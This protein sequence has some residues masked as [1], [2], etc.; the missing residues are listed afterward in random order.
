MLSGYL[1]PFLVHIYVVHSHIKFAV[2]SVNSTHIIW[3]LALLYLRLRSGSFWYSP[4]QSVHQWLCTRNQWQSS[5]FIGTDT[6]T[7]FQTPIDL[8]KILRLN[9]YLDFHYLFP[10]LCLI[11]PPS[12]SKQKRLAEKAAK[13]NAGLGGSTST[14]TTPAGS[15]NGSAINT[16]MT[17]MS[18]A[19]STD[20]LTSMAKLNLATDRYVI[21]RSFGLPP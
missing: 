13:K 8:C 4:G 19:N 21:K 15:T 18:A 11:M 5:I 12:A 16:P 6:A 3:G 14:S 20:D 7:F 9:R 17:S 1:P 2:L 10:T